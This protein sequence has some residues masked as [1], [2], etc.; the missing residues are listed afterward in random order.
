[1]FEFEKL[2]WADGRVRGEKC[3]V[4]GVRAELDPDIVFYEYIYVYV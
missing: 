3:G 4:P 2:V 1:V